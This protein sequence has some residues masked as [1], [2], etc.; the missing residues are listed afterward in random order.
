[1]LERYRDR[2]CSFNDDIQG[3]SAVALAALLAALRRTGS[4]LAEQR[5]VILGAGSAGTG[6]A[7]QFVSAL[8]QEGLSPAEAR[9]RLWLVDR[10][11]LLHT[12]LTDLAPFQ[13]GHCQPAERI[14]RWPRDTA[15]GI[16]L[17]EVVQQVHP[18][19]L[20]GVSGQPGAFAEDVVRSMAA[21]V[22]RPVIL[23]LSNPTT[24]S[25]AT[26]ADLLAWTGGRALV[27]TG[28]PFPDVARGGSTVAVSQCNNVYI[29]PGVGLGVIAAGALRVTDEMFLAAARA[30]SDCS[31]VQPGAG[32]PLFPPL[33]EL[34]AISRR[35]ALAVGA[36]AQRQGL[37]KPLAPQVWERRV[38]ELRW[39]P[40]YWPMRR[41]R[42]GVR[43]S[44][45]LTPDCPGVLSEDRAPHPG[46]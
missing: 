4:R 40:R 45:L 1:L 34:R 14:A 8:R 12:G 24:H 35:I 26:P 20:I 37:A 17:R 16:P 23:P 31:Q 21:H 15:G 30:L 22:E 25:E 18:T 43:S 28:S 36:E 41:T 33:T 3:T 7:D 9:Q 46:H 6:I 19:V 27:A 39:E 11:G 32:A 42:T 2:L 29:F 13:R 38:D 44:G 10:G 5:V